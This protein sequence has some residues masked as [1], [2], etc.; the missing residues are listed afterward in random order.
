MLMNA[1]LDSFPIVTSPIT[2]AEG[3][4][5]LISETLG[6]TPS[7]ATNLV[8]GT[9]F[10]V[11]LVTSILFPTL[12][13]ADLH[14]ATEIKGRVSVKTNIRQPDKFIHPANKRSRSL[15]ITYPIFRMTL[16]RPREARATK[17][18]ILYYTTLERDKKMDLCLVGFW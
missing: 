4:T 17:D 16:A 8:L 15:L 12:S 1:Y 13:R 18:V 7:T 14:T 3:A 2:D 11:Y 6:A 10:S 5:K 9:S